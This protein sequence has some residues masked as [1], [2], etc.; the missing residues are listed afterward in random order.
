LW[1]ELEP[2]LITIGDSLSSN[3][4]GVT[5]LV[6]E[7]SPAMPALRAHRDQIILVRPDRYV[8]AAFWVEQADKTV[9]AFR[10]IM[11]PMPND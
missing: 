3:V 8:A 9:S 2:T 1:P 5:T 10:A 6:P 11:D 7:A 4:D